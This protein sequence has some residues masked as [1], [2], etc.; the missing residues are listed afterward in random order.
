MERD[1]ILDIAKGLGIILVIMGHISQ[2]ALLSR[3]IYTFHMPLFFFA[4]GISL[5]FTLQ[6]QDNFKK[7]FSKKFFSIIVP[8]IIF[9]IIFLAYW[10]VLEKHFREPSSTSALSVFLNIFVSKADI[11]LYPTN[12][13]LWFL[14]CLFSS[15]IISYFLIKLF[16]KKY[17]LVSVIIFAIGFILSN[18][19]IYM[20]FAL[21]TAMIAQLFVILGYAF[22]SIKV[23]NENVLNNKFLNYIIF[24][25]LLVLLLII[26]KLNGTVNMLSHIYNNPVYFVI[27]ALSG[28]GIVFT[29]ANFINYKIKFAKYLIYLGKSSFVLMIVHEPV[30]R[31]LI[32]L[33]STICS[34]SQ[35]FLRTNILSVVILTIL[36]ILILIPVNYIINN[37]MP[38][39]IGKR[40]VKVSNY[41]K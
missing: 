33:A 4:S 40:K 3:F 6:K 11:Q 8:Y 26:I 23:S 16:K 35:E 20:P 2:N 7:F 31:I 13:V 25:L 9:S 15:L 24:P 19:K 21:E 37:Y 1:N 18:S 29:L 17:V 39:L 14:P 30:K 5:F 12:A 22:K 41:G 34:V 28:I 38:F 27:G 36:L 32:K 10:I